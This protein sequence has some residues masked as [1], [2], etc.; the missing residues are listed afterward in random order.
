M[1]P[2]FE[3]GFTPASFWRESQCAVH[4][5][6]KEIGGSLSGREDRVNWFG[7]S[8][9][10]KAERAA[11]EAQARAAEESARQARIETRLDAAG[12]PTAFRGRTFDNFIVETDEMQY[13]LDVARG[14]AV[15]F[16]TKHAKEGSFLVMGGVTGTGKSHLALAIAQAVMTRGTAMYMDVVDLI[17]RVRGTWRND[18]SMSEEEMFNLLGGV[19]DLLIIDEVG[20]QRGTDDEQNVVFDVINR[21][22]RD[23]RPTILLTNLDGKAFIEFMGPRVMSRL[24]ERAQYLRF[25]WDDWRRRDP[26]RAA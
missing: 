21:R 15:N 20:V 18:S 8:I 14:F 6:Y 22:Y 5:D 23:N 7:C 1:K 9:C 10:S 16:W 19:I 13:A 24:S 4:G 25:Q 11:E 17:R 12:I 3:Q 26:R 2:F